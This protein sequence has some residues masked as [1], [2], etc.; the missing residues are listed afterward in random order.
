MT[1]DS[2]PF[3]AFRRLFDQ[4]GT[5]GSGSP[6]GMWWPLSPVPIPGMAGSGTL[7]PEDRTKQAV[8][9]LYDALAALSGG[10]SGTAASDFWSQYL[11]AFDVDASA[12]GPEKL[13]AATLRTYRV[14]FF[15]LTQLLVESYTLR[16]VHDELVVADHRNATGTQEWLWG[17]PQSDREQL[18]RRCTDVPDD[19]VGEMASLRRRRDELLYTF[20]GWD[21]VTVDE[22]LDDLRRSLEVLTALD[23]RA[24]E[25]SPFSYLPNGAT[26]GDDEQRKR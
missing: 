22:S 12:F 5:V 23:D 21:D 14:W 26:D 13:T 6:V 3:D 7:S 20:G 16:L 25:G 19:L 17:L 8:K 10:E 11:D 24:T 18:L 2:D 4:F 1:D 15:S 9:Q